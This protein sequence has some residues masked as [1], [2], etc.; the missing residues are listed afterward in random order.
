MPQNAPPHYTIPD[1]IPLAG[2]ISIVHRMY[3]IHMDGQAIA[4]GLKTGQIP[5]FMRISREPGITQDDLAAYYIIDKGTVARA[6]RRMEEHGLITRTP[7]PDNRR[8]LRLF[9][10][11]RGEA[12]VPRVFATDRDWDKRVLSGLSE[13]ERRNLH[14]IFQKMAVQSRDIARGD[15]DN[16]SE[17]GTEHR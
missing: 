10:T 7:D 13:E 3:S 5:F 4:P 15:A 14:A 17:F 16:G 9:L 12:A 6:A 8:K 2:L 11:A 1:D